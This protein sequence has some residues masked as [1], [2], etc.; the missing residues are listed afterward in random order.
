MQSYFER[1]RIN[2]LGSEE[3]QNKGE[4]VFYHCNKNNSN[5]FRELTIHVKL[6][7]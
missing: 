4:D 2:L 1:F 7:I 6:A 5:S 3:V